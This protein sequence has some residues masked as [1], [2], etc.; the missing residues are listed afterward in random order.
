MILRLLLLLLSRVLKRAV[1]HSVT[2]AIFDSLVLCG[3]EL[4]LGLLVNDLT[5]RIMLRL[6]DRLNG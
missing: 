5:T 6:K 1:L 4:P 3:K 2:S